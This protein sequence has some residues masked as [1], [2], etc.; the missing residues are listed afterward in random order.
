MCLLYCLHILEPLEVQYE[1]GRGGGDP[2]GFG[3]LLEA[4]AGV[5][6]ELVVVAQRLNCAARVSEQ[7]GRGRVS[8]S[9]LDTRSSDARMRQ[10]QTVRSH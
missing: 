6:V 5:T 3:R 10:T 1:A 4:A 7:Q 8:P 9:G 2:H